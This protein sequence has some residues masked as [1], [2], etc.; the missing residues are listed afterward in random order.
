MK[1]KV[2]EK[3]KDFIR[4][5]VNGISVEMAN[6]IRRTILREIPILAVD[7]VDFHENTSAFFD[8]I[9]AHRIAMIP[10]KFN[11]ET[12]NFRDECK[13]EGK[14][15]ELCTAVFIL[16]RTGPCT[17]Y[18]KDLKPVNEDTYPLFNNFPIVKLLKGQK[19]K[20]EAVARLGTAKEHVKFQA[21]NASYSY[22]NDTFN[23]Y[24]ESYNGFEPE[25]FVFKALEIIRKKI[26]EFKMEIEKLL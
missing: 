22:N 12:I 20:L 16:D 9:I 21:A 11:P 23:F 6:A 7:Y 1:I 26:N 24:I 14:G 2:I 10:L 5:E 15:C 8:E 4:F 13:C 25:Y 17:V 18:S 19:L 3:G